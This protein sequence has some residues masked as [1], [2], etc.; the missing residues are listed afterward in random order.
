MESEFAS[1]LKV[2]EKTP[3]LY[4]SYDVNITLRSIFF[5]NVISYV[6][7]YFW[8]LLWVILYT[9]ILY[10]ILRPFMTVYCSLFGYYFSYYM[11]SMTFKLDYCFGLKIF[12]E[13]QLFFCF[14]SIVLCSAQRLNDLGDESRLLPLWRQASVVFKWHSLIYFFNLCIGL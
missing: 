6:K 3:G 2:A 13:L 11:M 4:F 5:S 9:C 7:S 14:G 12:C 8:P 1:I 10:L